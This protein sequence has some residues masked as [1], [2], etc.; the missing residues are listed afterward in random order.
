MGNQK[1]GGHTHAPQRNRRWINQSSR[2]AYTARALLP[3]L[4][5]TSEHTSIPRLCMS[6]LLQVRESQEELQEGIA[7]AVDKVC[8]YA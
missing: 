3:E 5:I 2:E 7:R 6:L 8:V 4:W 1:D